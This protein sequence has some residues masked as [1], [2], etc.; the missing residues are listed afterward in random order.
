[1]T[2]TQIATMARVH[3]QVALT[4]A[5]ATSILTQLATTDHASSKSIVRALVEET[6][7]KMH[8]ETATTP[9]LKAMTS[10]LVS[11]A[12]SKLGLSLKA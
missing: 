6:S 7:L 10:Y 12:T 5:R 11:Q 9:T 4:L 2:K 3:T 8:A 1:M